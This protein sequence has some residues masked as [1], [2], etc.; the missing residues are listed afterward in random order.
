MFVALGIL[1]VLILY[2]VYG[3]NA[4]VVASVDPASS[5]GFVPP[6]A[7]NPAYATNAPTYANTF[8]PSPALNPFASLNPYAAQ[9]NAA[10]PPPAPSSYMPPA[11]YVNP[12]TGQVT[13]DSPLSN[14]AAENPYVAAPGYATPAQIADAAVNV[15]GFNP[16]LV[17]D[18]GYFPPPD[19]NPV[20]PVY[21]TPVTPEP[22]TIPDSVST[23]GVN[24]SINQE[25]TGSRGDNTILQMQNS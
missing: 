19:N 14:F 24:Y 21:N 20:P 4:P 17:Q 3:G 5:S 9:E 22:T 12:I 15:S 18:G 10:A 1:A 25:D 23:G 2:S 13:Q 6:L 11:G 8:E 7:D 16:S